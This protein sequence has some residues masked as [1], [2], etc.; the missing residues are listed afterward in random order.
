MTSEPKP[1]LTADSI[2]KEYRTRGGIIV[3]VVWRHKSGEYLVADGFNTWT[4]YDNG[5]FLRYREY[6]CD[7]LPPAPPEPERRTVWLNVYAD[8]EGVSS[9]HSKENCDYHAG[10]ARQGEAVPVSLERGADGNWRVVS[11]LTIKQAAAD[12]MYETLKHIWNTKPEHIW[13]TK[14]AETNWLKVKTALA[15]ALQGE[16]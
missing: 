9:F 10:A 5:R 4:V 8:Y 7:L 11:E 3:S 12:V 16:T 14:P 6:N 13:N 1:F 2:G 15:K